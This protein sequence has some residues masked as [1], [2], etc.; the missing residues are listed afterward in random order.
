MINNNVG[1]NQEGFSIIEVAVIVV[2]IAIVGAALFIVFRNKQQALLPKNPSEQ[3]QTTDNVQTLYEA[4]GQGLSTTCNF[5]R[6][7]ISYTVVMKNG[8]FFFMVKTT[9]N[10]SFVVMK[11]NTM[12]NWDEGSREGNATSFRDEDAD[13]L[14]TINLWN[15]AEDK[16][17]YA[18]SCLE[19]LQISDSMFVPPSDIVFVNALQESRSE[20]SSQL[21]IIS[22]LSNTYRDLFQSLVGEGNVPIAT[23]ALESYNLSL[24]GTNVVCLRSAAGSETSYGTSYY[25]NGMVRFEGGNKGMATERDAIGI[26]DGSSLWVWGAGETK[27]LV[28]KVTENMTEAELLQLVLLGLDEDS[29]LCYEYLFSDSIFDVPSNVVF[30]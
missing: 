21:N 16:Q 23:S 12:W 14:V 1:K 29:L 8:D 25:N 18:S 24:E 30:E 3:I 7:D 20:L 26:Y 15:F 6:E 13:G 10:T 19:D 4:Y 17:L 5:I 2:V 9:N 22:E 28:F 11:N 27:G